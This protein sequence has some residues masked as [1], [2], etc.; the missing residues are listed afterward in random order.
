MSM[1]RSCCSLPLFLSCVSALSLLASG[2]SSSEGTPSGTALGG[3]SSGGAAS[4]SDGDGAAG[5]GAA[6]DGAAGDGA[7]N[8]GTGGG[9]SEEPDEP[10]Q[11]DADDDGIV[12]AEDNCPEDENPN[13]LDFDGDGLGNVCDVE[14][15]SKVS[16]GFEI[17]LYIEG[18]GGGL[19]DCSVPLQFDINSGELRLQLDDDAA[20]AGIEITRLEYDDLPKKTCDLP[21]LAPDITVM[22]PVME[23]AG[24]AF[25]VTLPHSLSAHDAGTVDGE[26]ALAH[27]ITTSFVM[28]AE[29]VNGEPVET[30][31]D[32]VGELPV[33]SALFSDSGQTGT[34]T[35]PEQEPPHVLAS[36]LYFLSGDI[37]DVEIYFEMRLL[38]GELQ[39]EK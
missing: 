14:V 7:A 20:V 28:L 33:F 38:A 29:P 39:L 17:M 23:N 8:G 36:G 10:S 12:D 6:G 19:S 2:C 11:P 34:L 35:W 27:P 4:G 32:P 26:T 31:F 21:V 9:T 37:N 30:A 18:D 5:D 3:A 25:P 1:M 24:G 22:S 15:F 13:Q 16:G